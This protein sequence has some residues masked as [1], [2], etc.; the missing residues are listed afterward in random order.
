MKKESS[1]KRY[2]AYHNVS[3][4][5]ESSNVSDSAMS[6]GSSTSSSSSSSSL[7]P[8][9]VEFDN[10]SNVSDISNDVIFLSHNDQLFLESIYGSYTETIKSCLHVVSKQTDMLSSIVESLISPVDLLENIAVMS[11]IDTEYV[12]D[13]D[14][15]DVNNNN[16]IDNDNCNN[17][18]S[19]VSDIATNDEC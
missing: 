10:E 5:S 4:L 14:D 3:R 2:H 19:D 17:T 1:R 13:D 11:S 7:S 9:S 15:D 18:G 6:S 16:V 12:D 8:S